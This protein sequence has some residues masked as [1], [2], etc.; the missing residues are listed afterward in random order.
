M[1]SSLYYKLCFFSLTSCICIISLKRFWRIEIKSNSP[2]GLAHCQAFI[3]P[4]DIC[5]IKLNC[6]CIWHQPSCNSTG[7]RDFQGARKG[8]WHRSSFPDLVLCFGANKIHMQSHAFCSKYL[9]LQLKWGLAVVFKAQ[10]L[11]SEATAP[12]LYPREG[13]RKLLSESTG[14]LK[15]PASYRTQVQRQT[16]PVV[17]SQAW[18]LSFKQTHFLTK[19]KM[20]SR[21]TVKAA[22]P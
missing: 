8:T 2:L 11:Y 1:R 21:V 13:P 16:S 3:V 10:V 5:C 22:K 20:N 15:N 19:L 4:A 6:K 9:F 12:R 18:E 17:R 14:L 7:V